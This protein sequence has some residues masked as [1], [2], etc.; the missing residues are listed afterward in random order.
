MTTQIERLRQEIR[1]DARKFAVQFVLAV[2]AAVGVGIA[3]GRFWLFHS[4]AAF[5]GRGCAL[6][7]H[8]R[9]A[10]AALMRFSS[11]IFAANRA[12]K[13]GSVLGS[14]VECAEQEGSSLGTRGSLR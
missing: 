1:T 2:A 5:P 13:P 8:R 14:S 6:H 9:A 7:L 12:M 4:D 3:I 10:R 11:T